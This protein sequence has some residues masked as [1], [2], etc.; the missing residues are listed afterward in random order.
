LS[1]NWMGSRH[2]NGSKPVAG[3]VVEKDDSTFG[4]TVYCGI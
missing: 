4:A 2:S 1:P 3:I